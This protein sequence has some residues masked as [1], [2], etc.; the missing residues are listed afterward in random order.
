MDRAIEECRERT[1][2]HVTL[3]AGESV[4]VEY[5]GDKPWNAYS[6]YQGNYRSRIQINADFPLTVD[7]ALELACHEAYP[8]H[9]VYNTLTD[10]QLVRREHR[11]ELMVQPTFSPQS[12][13]SEALATY[14]PT[15]A[16]PEEERLQF[17]RDVLFPI[18]G[19][20]SKKAEMFLL[21]SGLAHQLESEEPAIA[22]D[23]LDGEL[24][25]ARAASALE[26]RALMAHSEA[27]LKYLNEYRSYMLTYTFGKDMV[28]SCF[29]TRRYADRWGLFKQ[30]IMGLIPLRD[31]VMTN[32]NE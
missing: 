18:A 24:E 23:Y 5:V 31:C 25:W 32:T 14:A 15:V 4:T 30:L 22:R 8:G 10:A 7:R 19:L 9:H 27:T 13:S 29:G 6:L 17:E 16:F 2:Q 1:L 3:P 20:D 26:Q 11:L 21:V 12:F 28:R